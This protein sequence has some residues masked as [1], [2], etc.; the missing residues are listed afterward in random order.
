MY[1]VKRVSIKHSVLDLILFAFA[2]LLAFSDPN[3]CLADVLSS[4]LALRVILTDC[5][6]VMLNF[7]QYSLR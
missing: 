1:C 6:R 5:L 2:N 4:S 3:A 7:L